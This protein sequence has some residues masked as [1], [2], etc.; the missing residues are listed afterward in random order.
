[1]NIDHF[2]KPNRLRNL[3]LDKNLRQWHLHLMSGVPLPRISQIENFAPASQSEKKRLAKSI[4]I[5]I[6]QLWPREGLDK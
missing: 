2:L 3:R 1:M 4:G 6:E 5:K